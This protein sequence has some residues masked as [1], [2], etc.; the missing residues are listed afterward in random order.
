VEEE[1]GSVLWSILD[2]VTHAHIR[3]LRY[4]W[5]HGEAADPSELRS[6]PPTLGIAL[7]PDNAYFQIPNAPSRGGVNGYELSSI[8]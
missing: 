1:T 3:F 8:I 2:V 6:E 5:E 4:C 7:P